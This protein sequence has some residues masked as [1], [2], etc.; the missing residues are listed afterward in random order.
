LFRLK[1]TVLSRSLVAVV[2]VVC[3]LKGLV[4]HGGGN[5]QN[6]NKKQKEWELVATNAS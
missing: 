2:V 4:S 6:K 5:K 1:D 3:A